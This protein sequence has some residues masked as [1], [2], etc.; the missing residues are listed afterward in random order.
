MKKKLFALVLALC[1]MAAM[2]LPV[3]AATDAFVYDSARLMSTEEARDL[4]RKLAGL[5][6]EYEAQIV[7]ITVHE[8]DADADM[9]VN[10]VYD[11]MGLGYGDTYD[12]VLLL[13][14]MDAREYRILSNGYCGEAIDNFDIDFI[15]DAIVD[16]LSDGNYA[17]AFDTFA[18][19]CAYYL[20]GY[21][22]GFPFRFGRNLTIALVIGLV[23]GLVVASVL[24]AQLKTVRQEDRAHNYVKSGS[25]NIRVRNDVFLYR[26]VNRV[27]KASSSAGG[28]SGSSRSS[29]GSRSVGGGS[30]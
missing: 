4:S 3:W 12:G 20:D 8:G 18:D 22:N 25:L 9:L 1:L 2:V 21:I 27:R 5:S 6:A 17:Q 28:S 11:D 14:C 29:G 23:A 26:T 24:K 16:D 13:M 15:S 10:A 19:E 7:V 30:F